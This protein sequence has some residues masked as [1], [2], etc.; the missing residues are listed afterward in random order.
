M[1]LPQQ[2]QQQLSHIKSLF[3]EESKKKATLST[4]DQRIVDWFVCLLV[5]WLI[6]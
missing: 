3:R 5:G 1:L 2:Q 6:D 4:F